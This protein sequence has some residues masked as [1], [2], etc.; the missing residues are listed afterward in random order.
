MKIIPFRGLI[1]NLDLIPEQQQFFDTVKEKFNAFEKLD[2][3]LPAQPPAFYVFRMIREGQQATGLICTTH[4][5]DY[6]QGKVLKHEKTIRTKEQIQIDLLLERG[7]AVKPA[8]LVHRH[9]ATI[10]RWLQDYTLAHPPLLQVTFD[11]GEQHQLWQVVSDRDISALQELYSEKLTT[12]AIADG[13]HRFASFARLYRQQP[14]PEVFSAVMTAYFPED[15][16]KIGAFHRMVEIPDSEKQQQLLRA[17]AQL[18]TLE[19]LPEPTL[20]SHRHQMSIGTPFGWFDFTWKPALLA[21]ENPG[22]PLLDVDLLQD[23][24]LV[25]L[26]GVKNIRTDRRIHYIE[27]S[28]RMERLVKAM[29]SLPAGF[30]FLLHPI[31]PEDFLKIAG[32]PGMVLVPKATFFLPRLK[33]GLVVQP[34]KTI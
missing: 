8:L 2:Y 33:N 10:R 24:I 17:L 12:V 4:I 1:P 28:D 27:G 14:R 26:L 19:K 11:D 15:E 7:A 13:H 29:R 5:Q 3:F 9:E 31:E 23:N 18:G 32:I 6:L 34:L 20:P 22:K 30:C 21:S 25:P 16:L